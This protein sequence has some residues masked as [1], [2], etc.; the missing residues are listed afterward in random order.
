MKSNR[1]ARALIVFII[2]FGH[3]SVS[4]HLKRS[5]CIVTINTAGLSNGKQR[6]LQGRDPLPISTYTMCII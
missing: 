5:V 2:V 3:L 6:S 1:E 4:Q